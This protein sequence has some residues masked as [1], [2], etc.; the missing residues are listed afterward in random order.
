M[1]KL[2]LLLAL[3][4]LLAFPPYTSGQG[5]DSGID[6]Y[7]ENIPGAGGDRPS[8]GGNKGS[9]GS[10]GSVEGPGGT[11]GSGSAGGTGSALSP[12]ALDTL[13]AQGPVGA[14]VAGL[15]EATAPS[16]GARSAA[17]DRGAPGGAG[18]RKGQGDEASV[19]AASEEGASEEGSGP[20]NVLDALFGGL[21]GGMGIALPIILGGGLLAALLSLVARHRRGGEH[22]PSA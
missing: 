21:G 22:A 11:G 10:G 18:P 3:T 9:G 4:A 17:G 5:P 20:A 16:A 2:P 14:A 8:D 6:Q 7:Q 19:T 12:Q 13:E 1:R 15:A